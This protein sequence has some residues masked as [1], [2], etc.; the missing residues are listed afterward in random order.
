[1]VVV[2]SSRLHCD[3][4]RVA[5]AATFRAMQRRAARDRSQMARERVQLGLEP[6]AR[7]LSTL[8]VAD[9]LGVSE[10]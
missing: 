5:N 2:G 4:A 8:G 3:N 6:A 1:M 10:V 9:V 7:L